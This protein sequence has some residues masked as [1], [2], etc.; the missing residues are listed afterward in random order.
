MDRISEYLASKWNQ[1]KTWQTSYFEMSLSLNNP[2]HFNKVSFSRIATTFSMDQALAYMEKSLEY[3]TPTRLYFSFFILSKLD[4]CFIKNENFYL[5][6][7]SKCNHFVFKIN[8]RNNFNYYS[9]TIYFLYFQNQ[10]SIFWNLDYH[11][12][13]FTS[14]SALIFFSSASHCLQCFHSNSQKHK[15]DYDLHLLNLLVSSHKTRP[16]G[17]LSPPW[18]S[19]PLG[20]DVVLLPRLVSSMT[21]SLWGTLVYLQVL[22]P[23]F[24]HFMPLLLNL[25]FISFMTLFWVF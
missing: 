1:R 25:W 5:Y 7:L 22:K 20:S 24:Y 10:G 11:R 13:L 19:K 9:F 21:C 15:S 6:I 16:P 4:F 8:I 18:P 14:C 23:F 2:S 17:P 12:N 3:I